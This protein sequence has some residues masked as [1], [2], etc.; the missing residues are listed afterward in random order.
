MKMIVYGLLVA[1][2]VFHQDF[3]WWDNSETLVMGFLP[4]GLAYHALVSLLAAG[5]WAL[6]SYYCW[7]LD[8]E[9]SAPNA[10]ASDQGDAPA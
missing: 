2:V 10:F 5:T 6:A 9:P 8:D 4:I 1:L 7:P 3:W